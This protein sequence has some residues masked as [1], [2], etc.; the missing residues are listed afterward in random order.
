MTENENITVE[1]A[2]RFSQVEENPEQPEVVAKAVSKQPVKD[3]KPSFWGK[4]GANLKERWRKFL[5]GL[6]RKPQNIALFVLLI[7]TVIFMCSLGYYSQATI[8]YNIDWTGLLVFVNTMFSILTLLLFMNSFPKRGIV[9]N[10]KTMKK[11]NINYIMLVLTFVFMSLMIFCDIMWFIIVHPKF[12]AELLTPNLGNEILA[13]LNHITPAFSTIMVHCA[14]VALSGVLLATLP[15]YK[16]LILKI[17][18]AKV[19]EGNELKE[20]ID[21]EEDI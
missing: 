21:T 1:K 4:I 9:L 14:L 18:T 11:S 19:V 15:L 20:E 7:S 17:N 16:K 6:K 8:R 12:V 5:V 10:K 2:E 13:T 3:N